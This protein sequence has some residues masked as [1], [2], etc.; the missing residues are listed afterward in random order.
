[1]PAPFGFGISDF[2]AVGQLAW[3]IYLSCI[4]K[5]HIEIGN[6][7]TDFKVELPR[8]YLELSARNLNRF[9]VCWKKLERLNRHTLCHLGDRLG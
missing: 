2:V 9:T 5:T 8:A 3:R 1:M 7:L 6:I 4:A